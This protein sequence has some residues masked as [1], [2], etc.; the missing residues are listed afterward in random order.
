[1]MTTASDYLAR[2]DAAL[3]EVPHGIAA[4][5]RA[6][7]AEEL[8]SLDPDA[9]EARIAQLGDPAVIARE[10][11]DAGGYAPAATPA[12]ATPATV[13]TTSTRGFAIIA[14]LSL[15][16]GA[17]VVPVVGWFVGVALVL[18]SGMWRTGR[19]SSRSSRRWC[20]SGSCSCCRCRR[21]RSPVGSWCTKQEA[22]EVRPRRRIRSCRRWSTL[23]IC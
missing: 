10:A 16:V 13:P 21:T 4:D 3:R 6:G 11:M 14:A 15:S 18:A 19:R 23:H 1:M 5:I 12:S 17:F 20:C 9:A 8:S 7:I 2:L 22:R